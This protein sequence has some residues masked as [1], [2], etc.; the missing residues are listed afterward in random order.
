M[1]SP[2]SKYQAASKVVS[3]S[4]DLGDAHTASDIVDFAGNDLIGTGCTVVYLDGSC[5][6]HFVIMGGDKA[7][8]AL[9]ALTY[10]AMVDISGIGITKLQVT[11]AA[12]T[13][14]TLKV[15]V[16]ASPLGV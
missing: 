12:Q 7:D 9:T 2:T 1:L 4:V 10:P 5:T 6:L 13:G 14:L 11:N 16:M 8:L 3:Y 15:I